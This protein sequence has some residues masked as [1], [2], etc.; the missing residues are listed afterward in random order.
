MSNQNAQPA[1][2]NEE[3][4]ELSEA[5]NEL[6]VLVAFGLTDGEIATQIQISKHIT[7]DRIA[8]LL[9]KLGARERIEILLY[10]FSEPTIYQR[11][12]AEIVKRNAKNPQEQIS[13]AKQ[14]AS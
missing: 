13:W 14:K 10:A 4:I 3:R 1:G 12:I 6:I 9:A 7:V 8:R 2:I 5:D 11:T